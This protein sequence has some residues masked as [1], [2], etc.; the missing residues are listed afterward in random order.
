MVTGSQDSH[1]RP[2]GRTQKVTMAKANKQASG[3]KSLVPCGVVV[4]AFPPAAA[5]LAWLI[6]ERLA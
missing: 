6:A 2:R 5:G 3:Q 4:F 1:R